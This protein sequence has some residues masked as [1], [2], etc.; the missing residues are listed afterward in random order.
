MIF[1]ILIFV[2][3][4]VNNLGVVF[5][6]LFLKN[7]SSVIIGAYVEVPKFLIFSPFSPT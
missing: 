1:T 7:E 2:D 4:T 6:L 3:S 5:L